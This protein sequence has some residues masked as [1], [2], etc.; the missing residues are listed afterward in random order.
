MVVTINNSD[1]KNSVEIEEAGNIYWNPYNTEGGLDTNKDVY[2]PPYIGLAH[3]MAHILS[4]W[5]EFIDRLEE[6]KLGQNIIYYDEIY[7]CYLENLIRSEHRLSLRQYYTYIHYIDYNTKI[8]LFEVFT[9]KKKPDEKD[10]IQHIVLPVSLIAP[11][12]YKKH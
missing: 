10:S 1:K 12:I 9:G 7:A 5:Y 11:M 3:E 2:R 6:Y 8:G 4:C